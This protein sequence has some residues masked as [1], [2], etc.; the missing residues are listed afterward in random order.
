MDLTAVG[1]AIDTILAGLGQRRDRI[2]AVHE[3]FAAPAMAA[4]TTVKAD[5]E[6]GFMEIREWLMNENLTAPAI[7]GLLG[8][9]RKQLLLERERLAA[10]ER[11]YMKSSIARPR[12]GRNGPRFDAAWQFAHYIRMFVYSA[13]DFPYNFDGSRYHSMGEMLKL[14][15]FGHAERED[16]LLLLARIE[17]DTDEYWHRAIEAYSDLA[18]AAA[19][20]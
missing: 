18:A 4:L 8:E 9:R 1:I 10:L 2:R 15:E 17:E 7:R 19:T 20:A 16:A 12:W 11:A 3:H 13:V 6:K 5:Y 14:V